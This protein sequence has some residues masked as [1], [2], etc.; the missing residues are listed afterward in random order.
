MKEKLIDAIKQHKLDHAH[1]N[2]II[3]LAKKELNKTKD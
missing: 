3:K 1:L 2:E